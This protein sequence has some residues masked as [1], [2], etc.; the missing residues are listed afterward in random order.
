MKEKK[1]TTLLV[2]KTKSWS[3]EKINKIDKHP[4]KVIKKRGKIEMT[5]MR[6]E[7]RVNEQE[8][9]FYTSQHPFPVII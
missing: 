1:H 3:I 7:R 6:S 2:W 8:K 5:N 4:V 9:G